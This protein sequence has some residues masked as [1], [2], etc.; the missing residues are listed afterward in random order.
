MLSTLLVERTIEAAAK[1][2]YRY[3]AE[4]L[5]YLYIPENKFVPRDLMRENVFFASWD[6]N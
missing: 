6:D 2:I 4:G 1:L 5:K 3:S